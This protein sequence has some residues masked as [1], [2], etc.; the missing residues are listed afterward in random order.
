MQQ[1]V[2]TMEM[3]VPQTAY[4]MIVPKLAKKERLRIVKPASK[5]SG[6]SSPYC[7]TDPSC[8]T[9]SAG[10]ARGGARIN[11]ERAEEHLAPGS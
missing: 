5:I 11:R 7:G 10:R 3:Q 6:G 2:T 9:S 4:I 8:S 1:P